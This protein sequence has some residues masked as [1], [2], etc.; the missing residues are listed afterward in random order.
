MDTET[1]AEAGVPTEA[2]P[3]T[4]A[5]VTPPVDMAAITVMAVTAVT[6]TEETAES[7]TSVTVAMVA[8][9]L[10]ATPASLPETTKPTALAETDRLPRERTLTE[11]R[12]WMWTRLLQRRQE[13]YLSRSRNLS[14]RRNKKNKHLRGY[15]N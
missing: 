4:A 7:P 13:K 2:E 15:E 12:L 10:T 3:E 9:T 14:S 1:G 8:G 6:E 11:E 5:I